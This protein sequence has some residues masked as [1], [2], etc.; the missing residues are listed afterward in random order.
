MKRNILAICAL[1]AT[2]SLMAQSYQVVVTTKDGEKKVFAADDITDIKFAN[3]PQYIKAGTFIEGLYSP[4]ATN[5]TYDFTIATEEPDA[6][7]QPAVVGGV[8]MSLSMNAPLS[9][10]AQNAILPEG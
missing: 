2:A 4:N 7:G 1:A 3:A 6:E 5:A 9:D 10:E 8:Q